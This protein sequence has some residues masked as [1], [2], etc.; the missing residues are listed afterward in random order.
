MLYRDGAVQG[1][2]VIKTA[3]ADVALF[4]EPYDSVLK[5]DGQDIVFLTVGLRDRNGNVNLQEK[6]K[7]F[8]SVEGAGVLQ[9]YGSADPA[10]E[11]SYAS[12][13]CTTYDGYVQAAV[14]AKKGEGAVK[15]TFRSEGCEPLE[16][17]LSLE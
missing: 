8:V 16:I 7:I 10:G 5:A 6:K 2:Y 3:D 11:E 17:L 12:P 1:S 4:A 14:R 15:V 9:G 13:V